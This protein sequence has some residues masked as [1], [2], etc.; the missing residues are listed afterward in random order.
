MT[1]FLL[2]S[3]D[4]GETREGGEMRGQERRKIEQTTPMEN[5]EG[6]T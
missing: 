1:R 5:G 4:R 6:V 3:E 2:Q